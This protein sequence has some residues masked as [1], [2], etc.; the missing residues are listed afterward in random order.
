MRSDG[1]DSEK[2]HTGS[3]RTQELLSDHLLGLSRLLVPATVQDLL[4]F[5]LLL[6]FGVHLPPSRC[7][8]RSKQFVTAASRFQICRV[9]LF[10][11]L[12]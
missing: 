9:G 8:T 12:N 7:L 3:V 5:A 11:A 1:E 4:V 2:H 10:T 6:E